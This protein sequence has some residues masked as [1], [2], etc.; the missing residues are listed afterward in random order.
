[1]PLTCALTVGHRP[2]APG[3][4]S[5]GDVSEFRYNAPLARSVAEAVCPDVCDVQIVYREDR[6]DGYKRLPGRINQLAPDFIIELHFN[7][8]HDPSA[9]GSE[10]L[11]WHRSLA[12]AELAETLLD[13]LVGAL[14]LTRRGCRPHDY[15][16]RGGYLLGQT[17]APCVIAEPFFGS[18]PDDWETATLRKDRLALAYKRAIE[19][20]AQTLNGR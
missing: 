19:K 8:F 4:V 18:N 13:E 2:S 9:T 17:A 3:A 11:F 14:D 5:V 12:G 1:M 20:Y 6:R 15:D 16:D 10:V 7:G